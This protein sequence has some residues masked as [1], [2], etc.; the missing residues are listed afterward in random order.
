M[1][2]KSLQCIVSVDLSLQL[3]SLNVTVPHYLAETIHPVSSRGSRHLRS[4]YTSTLLVPPMR[5]STLGDRS[6]PVAAARAWNALP[7]HVRN[8][9]SLPAFRR[10]LKSVLFRLSFPVA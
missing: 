8:A 4:A 5:R 10:E 1:V 9:A 7:R 3:V 2:S 6:L